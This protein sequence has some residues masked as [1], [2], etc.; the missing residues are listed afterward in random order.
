MPKQH[1]LMNMNIP[2]ENMT[3]TLLLIFLAIVFLQSSIDK[4]MDWKNNLTWLKGHFSKT[5]FSGLV[6]ALLGVITIVELAAGLLSLGGVWEAATG[7]PGG[8]AYLA[9]ITASTA[10]LMLLLGQRIAKD[11]DGARTLVIYLIPAVFLVFLLEL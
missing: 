1:K 6:P 7:S 11:Y 4:I 10:L 8:V 3:I 9:A 2:F 5:L